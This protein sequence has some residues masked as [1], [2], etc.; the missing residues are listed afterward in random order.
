MDIGCGHDVVTEWIAQSFCRG[1]G[2][3]GGDGRDCRIPQRRR[4]SETKRLGSMDSMVLEV[5]N[6]VE[7]SLGL[8]LC[9]SLQLRP[10]SHT[11]FTFLTS[12]FSI[13]Q[14]RYARAAVLVPH[15]YTFY[16]IFTIRKY[17]RHASCS[18][19]QGIPATPISRAAICC[20][21]HNRVLL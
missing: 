9:T 3:D 17:H 2:G 11:P 12:H 15:S 21:I 10:Y 14:R 16:E 1:H 8:C 13:W 20:R 19:H 5:T 18:K 6:A 4:G 7:E